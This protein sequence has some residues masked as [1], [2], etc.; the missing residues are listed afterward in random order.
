[1][2][3]FFITA[4]LLAI[5]SNLAAQTEPLAGKWKTWLIP[6]GTE[7]RLPA[8]AGPDDINAVVKAQENLNDKMKQQIRYWGAGSPG[9]HWTEMIGKLWVTDTSYNGML[10]NMLLSVGIY[11]ATIAAWDTKYHYNTQRPF[12]ADKQVRALLPK[13]DSP[14]YPC[15]YSVAAGVATTIISQYYPHLKDSVM[16]LAAQLMAS[17]VAAGVQFP[18]DTEDGFQLG[19]KIAEAE[20]TRAKNF[21]PQTPW[22]GKMPQGPGVW[23]GPKPMFPLAGKA[24]PMIM[25]TGSE[26]RPAPPPDFRKEMEE[27]KNFKPGFRSNSNA[28]LHATQ[29]VLNELLEK[30]LFEHNIHLNPPRA[31]RI[32]AILAI[33]SYDGFISCWDAKYAYYGIRPT[34]Y[35]SSY[36]SL[37]GTPP[38]PG[39]PSGHAML[40]SVQ[41]ELLSYFFP[42][43]QVLFRRTAKDIAESRFQAGIHFRTDNDVALEMGK[44][45]AARIKSRIK[46]EGVD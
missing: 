46:S 24:K 16:K 41:A 2:R 3:S 20:I 6:S 1:M 10:A 36:K 15:E 4:L 39:Y 34:Q 23:K 29:N 26:F 31:A 13:P 44:Q 32:C 45:L 37:I 9:Y 43:E 22:D 14:S 8:P 21:L 12:A 30:K 27:M 11:D 5:L 28:Y 35:D 7:Y 42:E 19:K 18:R 33:G 40:S 38:F 17:R 25:E